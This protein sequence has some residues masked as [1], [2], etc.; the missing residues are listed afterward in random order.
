[1][2][3]T[4]NNGLGYKTLEGGS[5]RESGVGE[6]KQLI[7]TSNTSHQFVHLHYSTVVAELCIYCFLI[8]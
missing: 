8:L 6:V 5:D 1:M 7:G 2:R 3:K 4:K